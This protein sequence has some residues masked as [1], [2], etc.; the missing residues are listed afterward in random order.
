VPK[1]TQPTYKIY[2]GCEDKNVAGASINRKP[3]CPSTITMQ[4]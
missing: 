1:S 4:L 2:K 3:L